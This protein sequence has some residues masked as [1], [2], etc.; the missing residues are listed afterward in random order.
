MG[1]FFKRDM[2]TGEVVDAIML[3]DGS[4]VSARRVRLEGLH[5]LGGRHRQRHRA[6]LPLQ[7]LERA[8]QAIQGSRS[9]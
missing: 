7:D 4:A 2:V 5:L 3:P 8:R 1:A 9:G 6:G